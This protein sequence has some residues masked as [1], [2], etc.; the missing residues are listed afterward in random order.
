MEHHLSH[1]ASI[2]NIMKSDRKVKCVAKSY[3]AILAEICKQLWK[4]SK[5]VSLERD[6]LQLRRFRFVFGFVVVALLFVCSSPRKTS[7]ASHYGTE[8]KTFA[9]LCC[10]LF[11]FCFCLRKKGLFQVSPSSA[12]LGLIIRIDKKAK[13]E[14][15]KEAW[16]EGLLSRTIGSRIRNEGGKSQKENFFFFQSV[17]LLRGEKEK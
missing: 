12:A 3:L 7:C 2:C 5:A 13:K 16:E 8:L 6:G 1:H 10:L 17:H 15:R 11:C 9:L 14:G 4:I